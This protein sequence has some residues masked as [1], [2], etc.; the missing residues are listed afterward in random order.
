M[1]ATP[2]WLPQDAGARL[3]MALTKG[4]T[5]DKKLQMGNKKKEGKAQG[6]GRENKRKV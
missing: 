4:R 1:S 3:K 6:K 2:R 5:K